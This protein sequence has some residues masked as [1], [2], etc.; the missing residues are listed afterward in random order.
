MTE[1]TGLVEA[2]HGGRWAVLTLKTFP[3]T[4][5]ELKLH[6]YILLLSDPQAEEVETHCQYRPE[7]GNQMTAWTKGT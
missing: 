4:D 1:A 5:P 2:Y 7:G 3:R 6:N